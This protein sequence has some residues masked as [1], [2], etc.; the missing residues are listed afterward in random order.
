MDSIQ[1]SFERLTE[2]VQ[3]VLQQRGECLQSTLGQVAELAE[4]LRLVREKTARARQGIAKLHA[5][6]SEVTPSVPV[7]PVPAVS[8][9]AQTDAETPHGTCR[10]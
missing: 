6:S 3:V 7:V 5:L 1:G 4:R 10:Q 2:S 9:A 8:P